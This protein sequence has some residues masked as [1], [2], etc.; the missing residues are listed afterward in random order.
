MIDSPACDNDDRQQ[1]GIQVIAR[2]S[3]IM[4]TL[5]AQAQPHGMS[6]AAIASAVDLPR[7]TVQRIINALVAEHLVEPAGP[8]GFRIGPALGQMLYQTNSDVL[9]L[10]KPYVEQLSIKLQETVCLARL[11]MQKLHVVDS[12]VGEQ[13]LRVVPQIGIAPPLHVIA[14]G[15]VLL[16]RMDEASILQ[17]RLDAAQES[18][19]SS[20]A[21]LQ[22][23]AQVRAQGYAVDMDQVINGASGISVAISTYRGVYALMI[24]APTVRL[25]AQLETF[26]QELFTV[27]DTIEKLLDSPHLNNA[28]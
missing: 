12:V 14:P 11:Q 2:T 6:L 5:S 15:Q 19:I 4:R 1:G 27:R 9:P 16:A 22:R 20:E 26:K 13:V 3:K 7:S 21:L 28:R 18:E 25:V 8:S 23:I 24:L 17:W 10:L